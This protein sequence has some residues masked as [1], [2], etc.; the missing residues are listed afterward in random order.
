MVAQFLAQEMNMKGSFSTD[1]LLKS[2]THVFMS[3]VSANHD[4]TKR[5]TGLRTE[6]MI[7]M[8]ACPLTQG[9]CECMT[10]SDHR[11]VSFDGGVDRM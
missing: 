10:E 2:G 7:L 3:I 6:I 1:L 8:T 4:H 11:L 5:A 9:A